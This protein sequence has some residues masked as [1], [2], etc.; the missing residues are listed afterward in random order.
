LVDNTSFKTVVLVKDN[1]LLLTRS[2]RNV[3]CRLLFRAHSSSP[4][5][6]EK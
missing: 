3:A 2:S 6:P 5:T 4:Q 1:S